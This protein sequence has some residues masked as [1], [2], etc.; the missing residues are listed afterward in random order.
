PAGRVTFSLHGGGR[1]NRPRTG[2]RLVAGTPSETEDRAVRDTPV[3]GLRTRS[4]PGRVLKPAGAGR[5]AAKRRSAGLRLPT[6]ETT[7][8]YGVRHRGSGRTRL[9]TSDTRLTM[10]VRPSRFERL[11]RNG[12]PRMWSF[13]SVCGCSLRTQ[14]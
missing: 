9:I 13:G 6:T 11:P 1:T 14:Q 8:G 3:T 4:R 2:A 5:R 12:V 10:K 7:A